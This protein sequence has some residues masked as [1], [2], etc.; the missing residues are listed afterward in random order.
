MKFL[1]LIIS[2]SFI[3]CSAKIINTKGDVFSEH[4][5]TN[6]VW[7]GTVQYNSHGSKWHKEAR[8]KDAYAKMHNF[9]NGP[10]RIAHEYMTPGAGSVGGGVGY[11]GNYSFQTIYVHIEFECEKKRGES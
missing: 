1:I 10:Y 5:P 7:G 3:G 8:R 6:E 11:N 9:C 2:F 4:A